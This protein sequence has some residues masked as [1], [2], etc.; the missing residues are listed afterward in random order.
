MCVLKHSDFIAFQTHFSQMQEARQVKKK[1]AE[2]H[3][4]HE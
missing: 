2:N 3:Y 1:A 4:T